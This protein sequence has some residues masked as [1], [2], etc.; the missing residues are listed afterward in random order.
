MAL[1]DKQYYSE[2]FLLQ[3]YAGLKNLIKAE[4]P[5]EEAEQEVKIVTKN[6]SKVKTKTKAS[7]HHF[8]QKTCL[9]WTVN[10]FSLGFFTF[11]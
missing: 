9:Q 1:L 8:S 6:K 4:L 11:A 5:I 10:N 2:S 7:R 3:V